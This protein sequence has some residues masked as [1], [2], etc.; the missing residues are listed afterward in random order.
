MTRA[1]FAASVLLA[2]CSGPTLPEDPDVSVAFSYSEDVRGFGEYESVVRIRNDAGVPIFMGCGSIKI[3]VERE[4]AWRTVGG[5]SS[6]L[7]GYGSFSVGAGSTGRF[8]YSRP[9]E[10]GR[11]RAE[12]TF[13]IAGD[14]RAHVAVSEVVERGAP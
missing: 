10:Y 8:T 9:G 4:G 11:L 3:Q 14:D 6:C 13:G 1:L 2:A 5:N 7:P 12:V